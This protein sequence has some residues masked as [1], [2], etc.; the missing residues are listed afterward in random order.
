M[1][2]RRCLGGSGHELGELGGSELPGARRVRTLLGRLASSTRSL[3]A[4]T[5]TSGTLSPDGIFTPLGGGPGLMGPPRLEEP[6]EL[7]R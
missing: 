7:G 3:L 2:G 5:E 4:Q 1:R 6:V